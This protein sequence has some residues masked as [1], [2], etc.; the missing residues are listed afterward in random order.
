M[1]HKRMEEPK[2]AFQVE[3][4]YL[5]YGWGNGFWIDKYQG[6]ISPR[7]ARRGRFP[8]EARR[9]S[10]LPL[11]CRHSDTARGRIIGGAN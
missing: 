9:R 8:F 5:N 6:P 4:R 10:I 1:P 7:E 2:Y 3:L 11:P